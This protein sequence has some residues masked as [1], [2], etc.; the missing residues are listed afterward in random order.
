MLL[1]KRVFLQFL[2]CKRINA[3]SAKI[4]R[5]LIARSENVREQFRS[6]KRYSMTSKNALISL[7]YIADVAIP[8]N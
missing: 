7:M 2:D 8:V 5:N 4:S 1:G 3:Q 6:L